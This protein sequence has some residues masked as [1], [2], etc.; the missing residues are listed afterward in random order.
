MDKKIDLLFVYFMIPL[1]LAFTFAMLPDF[2]PD[3]QSH[4]QRAYL[5]SNFDFRQGINVFVD[6]DYG[7]QKIKSYDELFKMFYIN[8][9]PSYTLQTEAANYHF[10]TYLVPAVA[11][12]IGKILHLSVYTCYYLGRMANLAFFIAL[13][14][15]AIKI[16]PK[17][18]ILIFAFCCNPM[19][20]HLVASY[21]S[22]SPIFAVCI[23][24]IANCLYL[25]FKEEKISNKDI[26]ITMSL[27]V[28]I[29]LVKYIYLP[30]F[31]IYFCL[32]K[33]LLK[34]EKKQWI[35]ILVCL[36]FGVLLYF[37]SKYLK[38]EFTTPAP[39]LEHS[40]IM[41]VDGAKQIQFLLS[42]KLNLFKMFYSTLLEKKSFYLNTMVSYLGWFTIAIPTLSYYLFFGIL[43]ASVCVE[44]SNMKVGRRAWSTFIVVVD[45]ALII[46]GMYLFW[47]TVGIYVTDGVQGRYF[48]PLILLL[49]VSLSNGILKKLNNILYFIPLFVLINVPVIITIFKYFFLTYANI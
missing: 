47:T 25:F 30:I 10:I 28:F 22:D 35:T 15:Y 37:L 32:F 7:V 42:D 1:G 29:A 13:V 36:L 33:K 48:L 27:I 14:S 43:I 24:A 18:K 2:I 3:E 26:I 40:K 39:H 41:K 16:T 34:I 6:S 12:V 45:A 5:L 19:L 21:S 46:L 44:S 38:T 9:H 4:F 11:L 49:G 23:L 31:G 20:I 8:L 17:C